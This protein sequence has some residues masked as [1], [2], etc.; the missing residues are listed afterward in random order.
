M[1]TFGHIVLNSGKYTTYDL[2]RVQNPEAMFQSLLPVIKGEVT[3]TGALIWR[4]TES[5][6]FFSY[7]IGM[8]PPAGVP[9]MPGAPEPFL[10][11]VNCI[12]CKPKADT[13]AAW[14]SI[15]ERAKSEA[16]HFSGVWTVSPETLKKPEQSHWMVSS[17]PPTL[18]FAS[19]EALLMLGDSERLMAWALLRHGGHL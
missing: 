2:G 18:R 9:S 13:E 5:A 4:I 3:K 15:L 7:T 19:Q 16:Q 14:K 10:P 8:T 1:I 12:V 6:D 17:V 11:L